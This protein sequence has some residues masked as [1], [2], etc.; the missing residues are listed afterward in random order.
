MPTPIDTVLPFP[1]LM[2]KLTQEQSPVVVTFTD[3]TGEAVGE[4]KYDRKK[5][6]WSFQGDCDASA[7]RFMNFLMDLF[8]KNQR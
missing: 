4:F 3:N 6:Q 2:G 8:D 7:T 1:E 5:R